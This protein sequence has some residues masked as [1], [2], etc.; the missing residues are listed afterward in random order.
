MFAGDIIYISA[1]YH[2]P[3]HLGEVHLQLDRGFDYLT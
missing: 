2:W 3:E 1:S